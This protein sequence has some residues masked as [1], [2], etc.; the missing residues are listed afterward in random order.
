LTKTMNN[1]ADSLG[2]T[3]QDSLI[4]RIERGPASF[5]RA[6]VLNLS[7][8]W[9]VPFPKDAPAHLNWFLGGWQVAGAT[10]FWSGVPLTVTQSGDLLQNG[11]E[12]RPNRHAH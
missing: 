1:T 12:P 3:P 7:Y 9:E 4:Y 6:H 2:N 5:Q 11:G 8:L 10:F